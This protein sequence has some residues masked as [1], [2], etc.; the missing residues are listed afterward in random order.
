MSKMI[1]TDVLL[2]SLGDAE[3]ERRYRRQ[4][5]ELN[6]YRLSNLPAFPKDILWKERF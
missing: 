6:I 4:N 2:R 1:I 3:E 5:E